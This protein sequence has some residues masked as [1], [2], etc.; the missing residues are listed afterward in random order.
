VTPENIGT[1]LQL[2]AVSL[3]ASVS[4]ITNPCPTYNS[5]AGACR[6]RLNERQDDGIQT[7]ET[8]GNR[9]WLA[10]DLRH[11]VRWLP[12]RGK[13]HQRVLGAVLRAQAVR[14]QHHPDGLDPPED[15][16]GETGTF[17]DLF[18]RC[19]F[20]RIS[21]FQEY[22]LFPL[23]GVYLLVQWWCGRESAGDELSPR[24]P[25]RRWLK[26]NSRCGHFGV[27][28]H[29][30]PNTLILPRLPQARTRETLRH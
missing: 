29:V 26:G 7:A 11:P 20:Y 22:P 27:G 9:L 3:F 30:P 18:K 21:I 1:S 10:V 8:Q 6:A 25:G 15:D 14:G 5:C 17:P 24:S 28:H 13:P 4:F 23:K 19:G 2:I 12:D 16:S